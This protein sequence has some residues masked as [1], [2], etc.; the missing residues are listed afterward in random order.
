[1]PLLV[2]QARGGSS[3]VETFGPL[4]SEPIGMRINGDVARWVSGD[5]SCGSKA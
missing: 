1:L 2:V 3:R 4:L 5:S